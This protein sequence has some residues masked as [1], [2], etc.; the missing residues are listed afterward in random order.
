LKF[1]GSQCNYTTTMRSSS[2]HRDS[3]RWRS[4]LTPFSHF[5]PTT[6]SYATSY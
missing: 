2:Y 4:L 6:R 3:A 1:F 5:V